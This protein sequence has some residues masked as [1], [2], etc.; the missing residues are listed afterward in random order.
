MD[1]AS[2]NLTVF[3]IEASDGGMYTCLVSN[4]AGNH[5]A[6]TFLFVYPYF[7]SD[8]IGEMLSIGDSIVLVCDAEAYPSP[9]HL[10]VCPDGRSSCTN[11]TGRNFSILSIEY[12]DEGEY[13]CN[14]TSN[15]RTEMS[16]IAVITGKHAVYIIK[17]VPSST[18]P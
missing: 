15:E 2:E 13:F 3:D 18:L 17:K 6:S 12:G 7:V 8:P 16:E 9:E 11:N 4:L 5:S 1:G 10:W 14:A